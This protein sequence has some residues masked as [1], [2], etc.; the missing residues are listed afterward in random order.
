MKRGLVALPLVLVLAAC[1]RVGGVPDT[2]PTQTETSTTVATTVPEV[3]QT[4]AAAPTIV[5]EGTVTEAEVAELEALL[6]E[7]EELVPDTETLIEEPLP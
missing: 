7:V 6:A 4:T 2:P 5:E 3:I 1:T